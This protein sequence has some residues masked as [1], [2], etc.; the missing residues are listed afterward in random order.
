MLSMFDQVNGAARL[1]L[2]VNAPISGPP[3]PLLKEEAPP[4]AGINDPAV[5]GVI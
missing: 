2:A 3:L 5:A 1:S 4:E